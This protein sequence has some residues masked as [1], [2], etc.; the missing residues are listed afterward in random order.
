MNQSS[1]PISLYPKTIQ[2]L[3]ENYRRES[4]SS[5]KY[6][7]YAQKLLQEG[8]E[9]LANLFFACSHS[10]IIHAARHSRVALFVGVKLETEIVEC[11]SNTPKE[12]LEEMIRE[13]ESANEDYESF[14]EAAQEE[15]CTAAILTM[16][17]AMKADQSHYECCK[18]AYE[19][20]D[21]WRNESHQFYSCALCGYIHEWSR[22]IC[23]VCGAN[24]DMF[25]AFP[26]DG[27]FD[28]DLLL[29]NKPKNQTDFV[30]PFAGEI[31]KYEKVFP[32]QLINAVEFTSTITDAL[33]ES[34]WSDRDI[35]AIVL[36]LTEASVNANEHGNKGEEGKRVF[37]ECALSN[38]FFFCSMQDEGE[39]FTPEKVPDPCLD[40]NMLIAH[41]RGLKL[42]SNFMTR[43]WFN[44]SGNKIYMLKNR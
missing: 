29:F 44:A 14:L 27:H 6:G 31:W 36:A 39:G 16:S 4:V 38:E 40:E 17:A 23:P 12:I 37:V 20:E 11:K 33:K 35:Y 22:I 25:L 5:G 7:I 28:T 21:F 1:S 42:I 32:T 34:G 13:E 15:N 30:L 18:E 26:S 24:Q 19:S 9:S 43:I 2:N 3:K 41:G 8:Y 10:E